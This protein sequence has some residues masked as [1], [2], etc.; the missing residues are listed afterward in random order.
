MKQIEIDCFDITDGSLVY[1]KCSVKKPISGK[2]LLTLLKK[3]YPE[4]TPQIAE[5]MTKYIL[6]NREVKV[7]EVIRHKIDK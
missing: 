6:D 4:D 3:Y 5:E 2:S 1:K 7:N